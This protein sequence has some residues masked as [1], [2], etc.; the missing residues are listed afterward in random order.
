MKPF[1]ES[2]KI[3]EE[4]LNLKEFITTHEAD[5]FAK[6]ESCD[7]HTKKL[8][9]DGTIMF[10]TEIL[11][12]ITA[13]IHVGSTSENFKDAKNWVRNSLPEADPVSVLTAITFLYIVNRG[14]AKYSNSKEKSEVWKRICQRAN[15]LMADNDQVACER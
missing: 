15:T 9:S 5:I 7:A 1:E 2:K 4:T 3:V 13:I 12:L 6:L 14:R 10:I 11:P 8:E